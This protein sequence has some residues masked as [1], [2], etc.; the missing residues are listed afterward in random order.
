MASSVDR[1]HRA[2]APAAGAALRHR[3]RRLLL[4]SRVRA[5]RAVPARNAVRPAAIGATAPVGSGA[6]SGSA[7][8]RGRTPRRRHRIRA[9]RHR[10]WYSAPAAEGAPGRLRSNPARGNGCCAGAAAAAVRSAARKKA[11][12]PE[13]SRRRARLAQLLRKGVGGHG[14][15]WRQ[16]GS[17]RECSRHR[18]AVRRVEG[19][20]EEQEHRGAIRRQPAGGGEL[21]DRVSR[22]RARAA[23]C[24]TPRGRPPGRSPS[25][26]RLVGANGTIP[27]AER[28]RHTGGGARAGPSSPCVPGS[29]SS[30][31]RSDGTK[32]VRA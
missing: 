30:R 5:R 20:A 25:R 19:Q 11:W 1:R 31:C 13:G 18:R 16:G 17:P 3:V 12:G 15:A 21:L 2:R 24:P 6:T 7:L 14:V 8:R 28:F 26:R 4:P 27:S 32:S 22:V 9:P 29:A 10:T 23:P